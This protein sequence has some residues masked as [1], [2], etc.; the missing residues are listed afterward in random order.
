MRQIP[1]VLCLLRLALAPWCAL[2]IVGGQFSLALAAL[3]AA[4]LTDFFDGFLARRMR[5]ST[6]VGALL[7]PLADKA[8]LVAA[9]WAMALAGCIPWWL[10]AIVLSRDAAI[11]VGAGLLYWRAGIRRFPP[12]KA[13]K[14]S[15]TVQI[16]GGLAVLMRQPGWLPAA[17]V[18][19]AVF[20][21]T[22]ATLASGADY[23]MRG[24]KAYH[25]ARVS[26]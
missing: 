16:L 19:L 14:L 10:A 26:P 3:G 17:V 2:L 25:E 11:L 7:D 18:P 23:L 12:S 4:G 22:G 1:N 20:S 15:T 21:I 9:Y 8:L 5:W 13:G 6:P 24:L